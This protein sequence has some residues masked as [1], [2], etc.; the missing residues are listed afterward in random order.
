M[1]W[2]LGISRCK[3]SHIEW[4]DNKVLLYGTGNYIQYPEI[5]HHGKKHKERIYIDTN[6]GCVYIYIYI[7]T[8]IYIYESAV[9]Q[10]LTQHGNSVILQ[11]KK[12]IDLYDVR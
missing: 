1:D 5:N 12:R 11:L 6:K 4:I 2:E 10:K 3:L 7:Y 8:F 9:Q